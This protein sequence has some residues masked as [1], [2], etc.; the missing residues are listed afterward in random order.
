MYSIRYFRPSFMYVEDDNKFLFGRFAFRHKGRK[1]R[2]KPNYPKLP[3]VVKTGRKP[4]IGFRGM[5]KLQRAENRALGS[6][7]RAIATAAVDRLIKTS[8]NLRRLNA[9]RQRHAESFIVRGELH[10]G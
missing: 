5:R 9:I 4:S 8:P 3:T 2:G 10:V 6:E 1:I 7:A